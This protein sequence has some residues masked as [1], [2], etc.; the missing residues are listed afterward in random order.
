MAALPRPSMLA[1]MFINMEPMAGW[2]GGT[3][4]KMRRSSG[5]NPRANR[6]TS[7]D[8]SAMRMMP[9][10]SAMMPASGRAMSSTANF[11]ISSPLSVTRESEPRAPPIT[12]A[13]TSSVSQM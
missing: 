12:T 2:S 13:A 4:G 8:R 3:S 1:A 5:R 10:Q 11:A 7:P 6:L 9:S